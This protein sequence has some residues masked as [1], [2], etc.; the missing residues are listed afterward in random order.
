MVPGLQKK[1]TL[2]ISATDI[3][4]TSPWKATSD[5]GGGFILKQ[6]EIG[7]A[8]PL[9]KILATALVAI[10]LKT[11]EIEK[12]GWKVNRKE[13]NNS[14]IRKSRTLLNQKTYKKAFRN[15]KAFL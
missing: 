8:K 3:F 7:K 6:E 14:S 15:R 9:G 2:K 1:A 10:K 11:Q 12:Q 4:H 5:F 13:S